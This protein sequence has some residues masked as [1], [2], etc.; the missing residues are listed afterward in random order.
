MTDE[1]RR[2]ALVRH[3]L[4][5]DPDMP[6]SHAELRACVDIAEKAAEDACVTIAQ[7]AHLA[8]EPEIAIAVSLAA[9]AKAYQ[10]FI[11]A[12]RLKAEGGSCDCLA[13]QLKRALGDDAVVI[14]N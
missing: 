6:W 7:R 8:P 14:L 11:E 13:C 2:E 9:M 10:T 3:M 4:G 12:Q 1:E 5:A